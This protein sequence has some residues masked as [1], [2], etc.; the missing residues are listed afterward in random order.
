MAQQKDLLEFIDWQNFECLNQHERYNAANALKQGYRED[1]GLYLESDA[2]EQLLVNINF[3]QKVKITGIVVKGP[4]DG[5]APKTVKLFTNRNS[6][7][8]SDTDS[9]P[10]TQEIV[11][12]PSQVT[13]EPI[14]LKLVKFQG[15]NI[16]SIF[17]EDNQGDTESTKVQKIALFGSGGEVFNVA[18]IKKVEEK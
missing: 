16:L 14:A 3:N 11:L 10:V 7:G 2:D 8:F 4:S 1:D 17:I 6:M 18:D 12:T 5:S 15:V 13:G 9:V